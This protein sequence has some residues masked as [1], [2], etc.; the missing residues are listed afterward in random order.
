MEQ[1]NT[2]LEK[3]VLNLQRENEMLLNENRHII[4][5]LKEKKLKHNPEV[6]PPEKERSGAN[7][8]NYSLSKYQS[9]EDMKPNEDKAEINTKYGE[10]RHKR[11]LL[12]S[13]CKW[14]FKQL[15]NPWY[16]IQ[17]KKNK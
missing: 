4:T 17:L 14:R 10:S 15:T 1:K 5:T 7:V 6:D 11:L 8:S 2:D 9:L 12:E 13:K 16:V 3:T